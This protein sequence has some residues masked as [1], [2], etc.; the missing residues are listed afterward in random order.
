MPD[1]MYRRIA[2]ELRESIH[3]GDYKP[4][5]QLPT[6]MELQRQHEVSRTT[7]R[8]ALGLLTTEGLI[9]AATSRGTR[10]RDRV[11]LVLTATHYERDD[12]FVSANDAFRTE[13]E[14]QSRKAGQT[15]TMSVIPAR[16]EIADRLNIEHDSLVVLRRLVLTIDD[17]P[18]AIQSSYY[19]HDI[20]AG[21]EIMSPHDVE[22]GTIKVLAE[23]GHIEQSH[24]DE[25]TTRPP[26]PEEVRTLNL[27]SGTPVLDLIRIAY[28]QAGRPVRLTW[29]TYAGHS[30]RLKYELGRLA[31]A[32]TV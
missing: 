10:V 3:R 8:Q 9:E 13:L 19:P 2:T 18:L 6:E 30:I 1:P 31:A 25:I 27:D 17:S 24:V 12:R 21:S 14:A 15:F 11:P 29:N 4:G 22:R 26:T 20:A 32:Q 5:D 7:I 28:D 23:L 16:S